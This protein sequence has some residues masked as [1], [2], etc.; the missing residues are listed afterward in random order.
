MNHEYPV[1][2]NTAF[3][4]KLTVKTSQES[5]GKE[6]QKVHMNFIKTSAN[7]GGSAPLPAP[8]RTAWEPWVVDLDHLA[9]PSSCPTCL[10]AFDHHPLA[11][12]SIVN[13]NLLIPMLVVFGV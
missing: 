7:S 2:F 9:N 13:H 6:Y 1:D 5:H 3:V 8:R 4:R 10:S 12:L 11:H